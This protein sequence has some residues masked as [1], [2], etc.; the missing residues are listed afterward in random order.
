MKILKNINDLENS[1]NNVSNLGFVPTMGGLHKGHISLIKESK[2]KSNKT[3]VSIFVNPMQ[4]DNRKDFKNYPRRIKKDLNILKKLKINFLFLPKND[5]I[6]KKR[7]KFIL[8]TVDRI[9]CA[10]YRK[11]HFE[12]VLNIVDKFLYLIK[13]K[14][15]FLGEKDFQ[16]FFLI[17]KYL[18]N[19]HKCRFIKC[20]T[21]RDKNLVALSTRNYL[22]SNKSLNTASKIAKIL[23]KYKKKIVKDKKKF[24]DIK[25]IKQNL[26]KK[27]RIKIDYLELRNEQNLKIYNKKN[28]FRLFIA[29]HLNNIRL[30]DNF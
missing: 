3:L 6:L 8:R 12:G 14:Y 25:N 10:K 21:I 16:Q 28:K 11:G 26:L 22:L 1:I 30:I 20:K 2:K 7:N 4:F 19:M 17:K 5:Q 15:I 24:N 9:M 29:Y 27:F 23:K 13:P 18:K